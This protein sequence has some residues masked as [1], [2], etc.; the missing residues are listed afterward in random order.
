LL[1]E[2]IGDGPTARDMAK[3]RRDVIPA[4]QAAFFVIAFF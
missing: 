4:A 2:R 1:T 3:Q